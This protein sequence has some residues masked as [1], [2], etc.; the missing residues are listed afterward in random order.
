[1]GLADRITRFF[2]GISRKKEYPLYETCS[3][4]GERV[5]LPFFCEY[6]RHYYCDKHRLP[7][8]HDCKNIGKWKEQRK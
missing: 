5:Y 4:C 3:F 2:S 1:M 6:C 8:N 7:F